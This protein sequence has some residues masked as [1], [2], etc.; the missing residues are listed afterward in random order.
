M[1]YEIKGNIVKIFD[2]KSFSEK[3]EKREFVIKTNEDYPQF[4]KL[5]LANKNIPLLDEYAEGDDVIVDFSVT[6]SDSK[7]GVNYWNNLTAWRLKKTKDSPSESVSE[8]KPAKKVV[9]KEKQVLP[10]SNFNNPSK[11]DDDMPF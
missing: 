11:E 4:V 1:S 3:F 6:G 8:P 9:K 10:E 2:K 7:D 5:T